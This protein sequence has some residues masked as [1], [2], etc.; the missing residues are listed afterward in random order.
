MAINPKNPATDMVR[1]LESVTKSRISD[2]RAENIK[3]KSG[4]SDIPLAKS[5]PV[6]LD[7]M[8]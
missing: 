4:K 6:F 5:N 3:I 2:E 1:A 7:L 8:G